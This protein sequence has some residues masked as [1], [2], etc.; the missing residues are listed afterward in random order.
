MSDTTSTRRALVLDPA[1]TTTASAIATR[2]A[3]AGYGVETA[4]D[5]PGEP[6]GPIDAVVHEPGL[7]DDA[8]SGHAADQLLTAVERLRPHLRTRAEGGS[9]I[10]V[11]ASRDGLGWPSRADLA[12]QS[13]ALV[14]AARSLALRLGRTG[15]TVNV[16]AAL[17]P[18]G[19]P[20]RDAGRPENTHLY[21]PEALTPHPVT[22][23]DIAETAA[24][25]L[26]A[27]SG[28]ITGQVLYVCGGASLLSSLSV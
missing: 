3:S 1:G 11:V 26:D 2:L 9:R 15:I 8:V 13:G 23:Q 6:T 17:P 12:A 16:V 4:A 24:F 5:A 14:S 20:L 28:Y 10:L 22:T 18:E 7:L 25:L 19:S 27:R 21:E